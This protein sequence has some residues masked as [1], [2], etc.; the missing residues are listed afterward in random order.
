MTRL[1]RRHRRRAH[2]LARNTTSHGKHKKINSW[3]SFTFLLGYGAPLGGTSSRRSYAL[4][5]VL[6]C[7]PIYRKRFVSYFLD[8]DEC[9]ASVAMCDVNADCKNTRGSYRCACK[10]GFTGDG[11][12]CT[13][14]REAEY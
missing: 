10:A 13:G 7:I 9:T 5:A 14:K 2:S 6:F 3:V 11:K 4:N 12:T 1:H 8:V